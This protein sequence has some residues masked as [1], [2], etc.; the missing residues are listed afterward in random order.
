MLK[1]IALV[2]C[3]A[4]S[5]LNVMPARATTQAQAVPASQSQ[6]IPPNLAV[7]RSATKR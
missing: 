4:I 2:S 7:S 1:S 3:L 5:S 6:S